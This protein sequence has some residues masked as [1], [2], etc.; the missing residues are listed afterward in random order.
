MVSHY[1]SRASV[2]ARRGLTRMMGG[3][4]GIVKALTSLNGIDVAV[5]ACDL[6]KVSGSSAKE[7]RD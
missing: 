3:E 2:A 5:I 4:A 1:A 6:F 7:E